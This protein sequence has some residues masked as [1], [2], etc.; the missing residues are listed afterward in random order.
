MKKRIIIRLQQIFSI[1]G[2]KCC[3]SCL[4]NR[5]ID[6]ACKRIQKWRSRPDCLVVGHFWIDRLMA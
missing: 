3:V 2:K 4:K 6:P 5:M 1:I